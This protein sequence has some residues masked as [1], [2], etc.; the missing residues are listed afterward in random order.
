M[1]DGSSIEL[2]KRHTQT[3]HGHAWT[4]LEKPEFSWTQLETKGRRKSS[5]REQLPFSHLLQVYKESAILC[6]KTDEAHLSVP[7]LF[8]V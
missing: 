1:E 6:H 7:P 3:L 4:E 8:Q 2:P 5:A